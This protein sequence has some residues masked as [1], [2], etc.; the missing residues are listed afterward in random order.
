MN[1]SYKT[2]LE[3]LEE[4]LVIGPGSS[5]EIVELHCANLSYEYN[6][7][8]LVRDEDEKPIGLVRL[9]I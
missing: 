8:V 7:T 5:D 6:G 4:E 9:W 1:V 2:H 3:I